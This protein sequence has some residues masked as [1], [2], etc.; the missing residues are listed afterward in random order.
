MG[1]GG[2]VFSQYTPDEYK[3]KIRETTRTTRDEAFE[4]AVS[5]MIN[6]LLAEYNSRDVEAVSEHLDEIKEIIKEEIAGTIQ[7]L[8]GG[9]VSKHTYVDGLS[10][11]DVLV[12]IDKSD[13]SDLSP[14]KVLEYVSSRL[15]DGLRG[16]EDISV[17]KLAVTVVF[18]DGIEIQLLPAIKHDEGVKIPTGK[19]DDWSNIIRPDKF[20]ARLTK[21]NQ[22]HGSKVVPVVKLVK[23]IISQFPEN[24][25]LTG[26]HIESIAIEAFKRYPDSRQ[27]TKA[28][29]RYFFKRAKDIVKTPIRDKTGQSINVD[30]YLGPENSARRS[31]TSYTLDGMY[32]RMKNADTIGSIDEWSE[33]LGE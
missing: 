6:E 7:L 8:F 24:Q 16:V 33:I 32:R 20:A 18:S 11:I 22:S 25:Q 19:G 29:L 10:D 17:G 27:T 28:M 1:G 15:E 30:E 21:V 5:E 3:E 31:Q 4:T 26:Y 12:T 2:G 9:S 14:K 23:G 13:L